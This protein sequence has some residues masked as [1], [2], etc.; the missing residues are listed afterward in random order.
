ME[1]EPDRRRAVR[2]R[3]PSRYAACVLLLVAGGV[4]A[5]LPALPGLPAAAPSRP[6]GVAEKDAEA[7][8]TTLARQREALARELAV[9]QARVESI[10]RNDDA[11]R[12]PPGTPESEVSDRN[13]MAHQLVA[14]L[15]QQI[16]VVDRIEQSERARQA[17]EEEERSW[18]G[19][20]SPNPQSVVALDAVRD[21]AEAARTRIALMT[22]RRTMLQR[23]T[24]DIEPRL[25]SGQAAAR[26]AAE[27]AD[28]A[29]GTPQAARLDWLRDIAALRAQM[30]VATQ[31]RMQ[32]GLR[33][34]REE[35][36]AAETQL[37]LAERKL[38]AAGHRGVLADE[39]HA[40]AVAEV[41]ARRRGAD[42]DIAQADRDVTAAT[43]ALAAA[44]RKLDALR[45]AA[46]GT[47]DT[48]AREQR[49]EAAAYE[50]ALRRDLLQNAAL[51]A[52]LVKD[53][54]MILAGERTM[55][56]VR[57]EVLSANALGARAAYE[58][59][60]GP[61]AG[62]QARR[63]YIEQELV[64]TGTRIGEL[65]T[66]QRGAT[67]AE[68]AH[69][70]SLVAAWRA[71]ETALRDAV[72]RGRPLERLLTRFKSELE[73][74]REASLVER[75]RDLGAGAV[76]AAR[77]LWNYEMFTVDD[78]FETSDGRRLSVSR[79]I[80]IGKTVGAVLIVVVGYLLV[81]F[82]MRRVERTLVARKRLAV[83]SAALLRNWAL[84]V[85]STILVVFALASAS[86]P[87]TVFAFMGGALAIAAGFGLQTLLKNLVAGV[88]L[89]VERPLR[90]GDLVEVDG[91]RG[92]VT[93]IG[94]R[95]STIRTADG[96][97]SLIPNS[98]FLE[99]RL[100]NWTYSDTRNRQT[101]LVGVAYGTPLR[102]AGDVLAGVLDRHGLVLKEPPPQVYLDD[103]GDSAI[104][105]ALTYWV[106]M[107]EG[108]DVR[109]LRSDIM[110][111]IDS[112][113]AEAGIAMPFPQR[114]VHLD[115]R[116]PLRVEV[117]PGP[118]GAT[119]A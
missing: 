27:A 76:L 19:F 101:I 7:A 84:F 63:D 51:R 108:N 42:R 17:A 64:G 47:G 87:I 74:R 99:G 56:D 94:I 90:L 9:A 54:L 98:T 59:L 117:V 20:A 21:D 69:L 24:T 115:T 1:T 8:A 15:Q 80:T 12:P 79:S 68:A 40:R 13:G 6:E 75:A 52:D 95:A 18:S 85:A 107:V 30:E 3:R 89:L 113:F 22:A 46:P 34:I 36:T 23:F 31:G 53:Y 35:A 28:A 26:M 11:T 82:V 97:E 44:E 33:N 49:I 96:I 48:A 55:W 25:K 72:N 65:E 105:F 2:A 91:Q 10:D 116:A 86:I 39:D 61:L 43:E 103:Y 83:Q 62:I 92:R 50:V 70:A 112:A 58:R 16:D 110:H 88:I 111:M 100:V 38:E 45:A 41:D 93:E 29:H 114:D 60:S 78:T 119:P 57:R 77:R 67:G 118:P 32:L 4:L 5:Q 73:G 71:R 104:R 106:E 109:R 102:T 37:R 81:R 14:M 66:K